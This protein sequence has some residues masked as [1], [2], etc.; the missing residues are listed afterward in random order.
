MP[1][2]AY[3]GSR[4]GV[5]LRCWAPGCPRRHSTCPHGAGCLGS[6]C[7]VSLAYVSQCL[8]VPRKPRP[9]T[10]CRALL[11][12]CAGRRQSCLLVSSFLSPQHSIRA[13]A[14]RVLREILRNQPARFKNYAE[15][16]IMK[17]LEAH[18][19]SHKEVSR[20]RGARPYVRPDV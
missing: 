16:T 10:W 6:L 7:A 19:D 17:T 20:V 9:G 11:P 12:V 1:N 8:Q 4:P 15:L 5:S 2:L 3:S 13:L 18:K 14:L